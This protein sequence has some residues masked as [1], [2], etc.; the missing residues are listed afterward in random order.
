MVELVLRLSTSGEVH[1]LRH[2]LGGHHSE[3]PVHQR[4]LGVHGSVQRVRQGLV[5][6]AGESEFRFYGHPV[7]IS[8]FPSNSS[9]AAGLHL[10][11]GGEP[12]DGWGADQ[13]PPGV[14]GEPPGP[15]RVHQLAEQLLAWLRVTPQQGLV[16]EGLLD[17]A[18]HPV[19]GVDHALCHG[20]MD[21]QGL[22]RNQR[23]DVLV[24]VQ[25]GSDLWRRSEQRV[26]HYDR[27]G[28]FFFCYR[29]K[30]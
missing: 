29:K 18:R 14:D 7:K 11:P 12:A 25:L 10:R 28:S 8:Y 6:P 17:L 30:N 16:G 27:N 13:N 9:L 1:G 19:V 4:V 22:A 2:G 3:E 5:G 23:R 20:L 26:I 15:G 24:L 21:L